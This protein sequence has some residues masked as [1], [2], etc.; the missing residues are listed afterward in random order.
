MFFYI[1]YYAICS[2][3]KALRLALVETASNMK[4]QLVYSGTT[5]RH[6]DVMTTDNTL[7]ILPDLRFSGL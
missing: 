2:R 6:A 5:D 1:F 4:R 7:A 3:I